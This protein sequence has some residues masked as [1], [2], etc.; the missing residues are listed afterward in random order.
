MDPFCK[1][2]FS[3]WVIFPL[4]P[5]LLL[6]FYL[7]QVFAVNKCKNAT[8]T[9]LL[10]CQTRK[11]LWHQTRLGRKWDEKKIQKLSFSFIIKRLIFITFYNRMLF[12]ECVLVYFTLPL[13]LSDELQ[14]FLTSINNGFLAFAQAHHPK[15]HKNLQKEFSR[16]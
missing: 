7:F 5:I 4:W 13:F 10:V 12:I 8:H 14:M 9:N 15:L 3:L 1:C 6:S 16:S 2:P 11:R